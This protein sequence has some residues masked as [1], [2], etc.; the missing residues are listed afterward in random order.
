MPWDLSCPKTQDKVRRMV[1]ETQPFCIVGSPPCTPFSQLQGLN[2]FKRDPATVKREL[3]AGKKHIRFCL[4]IYEMQLRNHRHF[5]HEHPAGSTAMTEVKQFILENGIES[6]VTNMCSFG[7]TAIDEHGEGFVSKPTRILSS[8]G[9]VLKRIRRPCT[10]DH[11]HVHLIGGKAKAAQVYPRGFCRAICEGVAA[12]K[13]IDQLGL[14]ARPIMSVEEMVQAAKSEK[15]QDPSEALH[16]MYGDNVVAHDDLNGEKLEPLLMAAARREEIKYFKEMGVYDKV[17]IE[18]SWT[19]TGKA[20]I[21]VRWVDVNKGD[22]KNPKY[23]SRLVAKEFN[24]GVNPDL[25]AATPPSECLRIMLSM[26]ASGRKKGICMMHADVSRAYFYAKAERAVYVKLP[27]EDLEPGD[28]GKCGRLRMSMYGTR[29][30]ALNWSKEYDETLKAAG[31]KQ[32]ASNPCLF[33]NKEINVSVMVHGDDFVAVG[34]EKN[35]QATRAALESKYKIKVEV[36]G[37]GKDQVSEVRILNKVIR[38]TEQGVELEAD[39]R[40]VE[41]TIRALGLEDAKI[42]TVPGAKEVKKRDNSDRGCDSVAA[43]K[44]SAK[45]EMW[46]DDELTA[47]EENENYLD[48]DDPP[49]E[50]DQARLYREVAARLDYLAPDRADI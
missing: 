24:T 1:R 8:S 29:D 34:T 28:E 50:P 18:E 5:V 9:E 47:E 30:A 42:S 11:R 43:A 48:E 25:Y 31:F 3:E 6:V 45:E 17:P 15:D 20:P 19:E 38:L 39:P 22:S 46:K 44:C 35:L 33:H 36:V 2:N 16:E 4:E 14:E 7:M 12:Q 21:A 40:H 27:V 23:R 13:K 41:L 37:T 10:K 26:L 49:L 32:G